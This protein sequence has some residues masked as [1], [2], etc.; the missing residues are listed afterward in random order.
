MRRSW[1]IGGVERNATDPSEQ[2]VGLLFV[3]PAARKTAP[4]ATLGEFDGFLTLQKPILNLQTLCYAE[5]YRAYVKSSTEDQCYA[6]CRRA[7]HMGG[8]SMNTIHRPSSGATIGG[9]VLITLGVLFLMGNLTRVDFLGTM[10]PLLVV[11]FGL[12]FFIWMFAQGKSA[13]GLAIPGSMF[14]MLGL[15]FLAQSLFDKWASW[16][17]VWSLFAITGVG[18]GMV[19]NSWWSDK[20]KLKRPGYTMILLGIIFFFAFGTFFE[21][22][23]GTFGGG[24]TGGLWLP[25]ML[26]LLGAVLLAGRVLNWS[27]VI[28]MLPPHNEG[29]V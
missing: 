17:Y 10:G 13:G 11:A 3:F 2:P 21:T 6:A 12:M 16:A 27:R 29:K 26:I 25:M 23:F 14:V 8:N 5:H 18:I 7:R 24:T 4:V 20:P 15:I 28:E 9:V 1:G 22:L 19:I